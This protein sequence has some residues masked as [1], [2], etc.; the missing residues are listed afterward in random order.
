MSFLFDEKTRKAMKWL[1]GT[2]AVLIII[3]MV[4]FY[5]LPGIF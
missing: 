2:F 3:S 1:W 5:T 4:V